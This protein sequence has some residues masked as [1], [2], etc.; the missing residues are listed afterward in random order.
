MKDNL[1]KI[2]VIDFC[3]YLKE[4]LE[5]FEQEMMAKNFS[6]RN[7]REWFKLLTDYLGLISK[8]EQDF[9]ELDGEDSE[10]DDLSEQ[11]DTDDDEPNYMNLDE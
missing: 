5:D 1:K 11:W 8:R 3:E 9:F 10:E 4:N 6:S 2:S 7:Q